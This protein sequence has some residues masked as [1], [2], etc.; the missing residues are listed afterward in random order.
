LVQALLERGDRVR[1]LDDLSNGKRH[2]V[3][4]GA[5]IVVGDVADRMLLSEA[6][7]D[8]D[9]CFHLAAVASVQRCNDDWLGALRS[10]ATGTITVFDA[11]RSARSRAPIPVVYASSAAVYGDN[12]SVPLAETSVTSP[13]STYGAHKRLGE[14]YAQVA[15]SIHGL[16]TMGL[17]FFNVY[18]ARQDPASPYAGVISIFA[19]RIAAGQAVEIFGDGRQVRDFIFVDDVVSHLLAAMARLRARSRVLNVCTGRSTSVLDLVGIIAGICGRSPEI[20][21]RPPRAGEIRVSIGDPSAA[22]THF[23]FTAE[24]QIE[25]G[26]RWMSG[27]RRA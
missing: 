22:A 9:G 3:L 27:G 14:L 11:A 8:V 12:P 17:R 16:P 20:Q 24:T 25:D 4:E 15:W 10:N 13:L 7:A 18:G 26:L 6:V 2:E 21:F 19:N 5:E 1:V 23:G